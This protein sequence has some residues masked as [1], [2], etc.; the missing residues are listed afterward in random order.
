MKFMALVLGGTAEK[1]YGL[2]AGVRDL[3]F[4]DYPGFEKYTVTCGLLKKHGAEEWELQ[5][6]LGMLKDS[7]DMTP[8]DR[9][10]LAKA[11]TAAEVKGCRRFLIVGGTD[12]MCIDAEYLHLQ[13]YGGKSTIVFTGSLQPYVMNLSDFEFNLGGAIVA[14]RTLTAGVYI[15]MHG[16]VFRWNECKKNPE[17]GQFERREPFYETKHP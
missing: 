16:N 17:T 6:P 9:G 10:A 8:E 14:T 5:A 3:S 13:G 7:L 11:I 12:S 1:V 4:P 2:G 15:V